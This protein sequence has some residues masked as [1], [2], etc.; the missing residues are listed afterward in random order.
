MSEQG[1]I[2]VDMEAKK[3]DR[4]GIVHPED[5]LC[6]ATGIVT[7]VLTKESHGY[8]AI[9]IVL[10]SIPESV[11]G[12]KQGDSELLTD[13]FY[14]MKPMESVWDF[15]ERYVWKYHNNEE[16]ARADDLQRL[17]DDEF[18]EGDCAHQLLVKEFG[19]SRESSLG[20]I[21]EA[22]NEV[23]VRLYEDAII[24]FI[25]KHKGHG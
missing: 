5:P 22:Y 18:E 16:V 11:T 4:I 2:K 12:W 13:G 6:G 20:K 7:S 8:D 14:V 23:H 10:L 9:N 19:G 15:V 24:R 25:E 17:I 3:G 21:Q 1:E